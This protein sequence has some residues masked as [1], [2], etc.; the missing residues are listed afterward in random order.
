MRNSTS[1]LTTKGQVTIPIDVRKALGLKPRDRVK[2]TLEQDGARIQ[3]AK[4]AL[5]AGFGAVK[6]RK[7]PEDFKELRRMAMEEVAERALKEM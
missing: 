4:S 2:F 6:P 3:R 5:E 7:K 1:T